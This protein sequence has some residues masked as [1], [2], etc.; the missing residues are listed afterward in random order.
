MRFYD[1]FLEYADS[2][3]KTGKKLAIC[4]DVNTAHN[5]IDI[6][7]PKENSKF[8]GFLPGERAWMDKW[9]AHGYVDTF[10]HFHQETRQY[11]YWDIKSGARARD[12]GWRIDYFF[13]SENLLRQV[14][15]AFIMGDVTGSDHCPVGITLNV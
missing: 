12:V 6:A 8:S 2:L 7:R 4:G 9:I 14:T 13:V 11:S 15:A 10:R 1:V 3:K 5:E